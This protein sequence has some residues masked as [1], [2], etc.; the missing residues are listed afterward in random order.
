MHKEP[1][2]ESVGKV[3]GQAVLSTV[4]WAE[5]VGKAHAL[6]VGTE[7][8]RGDVEAAGVVLE[9]FGADDAELCAAFVVPTRPLGLSLGD[10][11]ALALA[12]RLDVPVYTTDRLWAKAAVGVRVRVVR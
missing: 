2:W 3:L 6:G 10:R 8:M 12:R 9:P 1:G 7:G 5:V 4:N 11:A